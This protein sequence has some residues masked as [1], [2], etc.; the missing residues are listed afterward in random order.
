MF[1]GGILMPDPYTNGITMIAGVTNIFVHMM[2]KD[3]YEAGL[4]SENEWK[5]YLKKQIS[6]IAKEET[7]GE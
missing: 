5:E 6:V 3:C 1:D 4:I 2:I 7:D